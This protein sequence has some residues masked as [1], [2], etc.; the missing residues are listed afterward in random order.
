LVARKSTPS[1]V[2]ASNIMATPDKIWMIVLS[3]AKMP[4]TEKQRERN[5]SSILPIKG[6]PIDSVRIP[7]SYYLCSMD[8]NGKLLSKTPAPGDGA[9]IT[10]G[11]DG[12]IYVS[13]LSVYS[14]IVYNQTP[15]LFRTTPKPTVGVWGFEPKSY[16]QQSREALTYLM[17]YCRQDASLENIKQL[18]DIHRKNIA[19]E[20]LD[21][22]RLS[23][24]E[25]VIKKELSESKANEVY[26]QLNKSEQLIEAG[27]YPEAAKEI[28]AAVLPDF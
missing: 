20:Q 26:Q 16:K 27:Q 28:E 9:M 1:A 10:A 13:G 22:I 8:Y 17:K 24:K 19:L 21:G 3:C 7:Q 25:A 6:M 14:E 18:S 2:V 12:R 15:A 5:T 4:L 23:I 11:L